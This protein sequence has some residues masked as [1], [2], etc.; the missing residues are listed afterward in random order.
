MTPEVA[1]ELQT[2]KLRRQLGYLAERSVFYREKFRACG[3]KPDD[4]R[5]IEDLTRIPFTTK[6]ELR[7][8][9]EQAPPFGLHIAARD[10]EIVRV[11]ATSGTT[12]K[13]VFQAFTKEDVAQ[14]SESLARV[15]WGFGVRPGDR[16]VNGFALSMFNAGL[17]L[18]VAV[19]RMGALSIPAGAERK[20]EGMLKLMQLLKPTV[21]VG[22]P[23]FA[24]VLAERCKDVLGVPASSLGLRVICGGGESGFELPAFQRQMEEAWGTPHI[25][26][27]AST[28][29]AHPNV[30][31]HCEHRTG[32]HHLTPD[33]AL[34]QLIDSE[35]GQIKEVADGEQGEYIFT[36]LDRRGCPLLRYRTGDVIKVHTAPC[37]CGRTG[38]RMDIVGRSDDML[39]VRGVNVFPSALQSVVGGFSPKVTGAIQIVLPKAGPQVV[40][41]LKM[42]VEAS[43]SGSVDGDVLRSDIELAVRRDLSVTASIELVPA[44]AL[45]RTEAKTK[46]IVIEP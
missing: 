46:L 15:L 20:V 38:W 45:G 12:G 1:R 10:D 40:P 29:D 25:Y 44:G 7:D 22:T 32:K 41:P 13:P 5:A 28:S 23:S 30:F 4:F 35:T 24:A 17:P 31:A 2:T 43:M 21:W 37:A 6:A 18:S 42:R 8:S 39:L 16:V 14:R 9:Q 34:V 11:T 27:F 36:H 19:E 33:F 26:D 3:F